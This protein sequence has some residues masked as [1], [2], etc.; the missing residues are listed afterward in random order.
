[1]MLGNETRVNVSR[2]EVRVAGQVNEKVDIGLQSSNLRENKC[3]V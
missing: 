2:S 3:I 1:M